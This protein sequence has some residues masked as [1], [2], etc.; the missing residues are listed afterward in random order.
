MYKQHSNYNNTNIKNKHILISHTIGHIRIAKH[1]RR[2]ALLHVQHRRFQVPRRNDSA[3]SARSSRSLRLL[4]C[5]NQPK[6]AIRLFNVPEIRATIQSQRTR[7]VRL[8]GRQLRLAI[9]PAA[10]HSRSGSAGS[11]V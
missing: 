11:R 8:A 4:L 2:F 5:P 1:R 6:N 3:R 9:P 10:D 7:H